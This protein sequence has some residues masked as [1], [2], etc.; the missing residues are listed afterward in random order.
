MNGSTTTRVPIAGPV[1][2]GTIGFDDA[3]DL[4][5]ADP[6]IGHIGVLA[7]VD[8]EVAGAK[9][10]GL[11]PRPAPRPLAAPASAPR[12]CGSKTA[13][14]RSLH[15]CRQAALA[16][17]TTLPSRSNSIQSPALQQIGVGYRFAARLGFP[18]VLHVF[19]DVLVAVELD[20]VAGQHRLEAEPLRGE[21]ALIGAHLAGQHFAGHRI[22]MQDLLRIG[23][24]DAADVRLV[25][26]APAA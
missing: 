11:D 24:A 10:G 15:A 18:M 12:P 7:G 9:P 19:G 5:A 1:A 3:G 17:R 25:E 21:H 26:F 8:I 23:D 6:W 16:G 13:R 2:A 20:V 14:R 22:E 4:V